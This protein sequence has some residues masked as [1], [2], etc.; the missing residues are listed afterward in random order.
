M[1]AGAAAWLLGVVIACVGCARTGGGTANAPAHDL[2]IADPS[3]PSSL[4]PLLAHDQDTIGFDL[5][6]VQTLVGLSARNQL[7]PVLA[8]RVPSRANGDV[9][10]DGRTIVYHLRRNVRFADGRPLTSADVLFTYRAI[11]DPRNPVLGTDAYRRIASIAAPDPYTVVVQLRSPWNAAVGELFAES[12]FA[13]GI[14]PAHAFTS[15]AMR[16]A[17][18]EA[19]AF[20]TGPFRVAQWRRSD[21]VTLEP[22]PYFSPRPK[23]LHI[24]LRMIPD[25]ESALIA[26]RTHEIDVARVQPP[27]VVQARADTQLRVVPTEINGLDY[28]ALQTAAPP[29][30]DLR[31]RRAI[32]D[33]L[34]MPFI[35]SLFHDLY[36]RAAAFLPP[37]FAWH[38]RSLAPIAQN[39]AAANNELE[40]AGWH[41]QGGARM[42][43]GVPLEVL[44]VRQ[45]QGSGSPFASAVQRDLAAVG[46]RVTIKSFPATL[47]NALGGPIRSGRFNLAAQGWV[48]S[49]DPEGSVVFACEQ[50]GPDGNNVQRFCDPA[51]ESAFRDQAIT[52]NARRREHDFVTMQQIVYARLP[53]I[54][55][56]YAR[57]FD[58]LNPRVS[59]FARNMLGYPVNAETWDAE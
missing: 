1:R 5:L 54:P 52:P 10:R 26:T 45:G 41:K 33:S 2:R 59:G 15:T 44:L 23:L 48:G 57:F 24:E 50:I 31:V 13:F 39:E 30:N 42:K 29:T 3:D 34:D 35:E 17:S 14:L 27:Q 12:D 19:H 43:N 55:M 32:A 56:D 25:F 37:V 7:T 4:N 49:G 18:W 28:L 53:V 51:F 16:N 36:P 9:S 21:R 38:D 6:F 22:N 20:G 58:V 46:I 8:R 47:F 40:S 11:I